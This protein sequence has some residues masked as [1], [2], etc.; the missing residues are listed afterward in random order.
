MRRFI[1]IRIALFLRQSRTLSYEGKN[2]LRRRDCQCLHLP[3]ALCFSF[4]LHDL[5]QV[6][7]FVQ[8]FFPALWSFCEP[9]IL[10]SPCR[11]RI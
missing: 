4:Q 9:L 10:P 8:L 1:W 5:G 2:L 3:A 6:F 7:G 11:I